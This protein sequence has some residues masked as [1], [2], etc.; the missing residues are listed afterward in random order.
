MKIPWLW[1]PA[2]GLLLVLASLCGCAVNPVTGRS[3]LMLLSEQ[4]ERQLGFQAR[5]SVDEEYGVYDDAALQSYVSG[6]ARPLAQASHRPALDWQFQVMDSPVVN[7]FAAPGGYV[8]VTR[9]LL[10]AVNDEAELAGVLAHEIG[11]VTARHSARNYSQSLLANIG[12]Q[13][14]TVLAGSYGNLLG[15]MLEAG[16]GLL[17]LK[18]SRDDERQA[19][20][21]GVEYASK[22][23]YDTNRMAD[24]FTTLQRQEVLEGE[25]GGGLP[26][27]FSTHPSPVDRE[28]AVRAQ[29]AQWRNQ[30][31]RQSY[32]TNREAFLARI[33][34]LVYGEDPRQGF[35]EGDWFYLPQSQVQFRIPSQ[36][37]FSRE[38]SQAQMT[39]PQKAGVILFAIQKGSV[40]QVAQSF[41]TSM[42][43]TVQQ[44][45][46]RFINGLQAR[47]LVS[48]VTDGKQKAR[49]ISHFFQKGGEVFM[50]HGL[51]DEAGFSRLAATLGQPAASFA[52]LT[53]REKLNRKPQR[54][55]VKQIGKAA[56]L[57]AALQAYAV[58]RNLWPRIAWMNEMQ[59]SDRLQPGQRI[60]IIE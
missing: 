13:L 18:Y 24:F 55:A 10:A 28:A 36:W 2:G 56:T 15:P 51:A 57:E 41:V 3:E 53:D 14:G 25:K 11:H 60:K 4:E 17:F 40:E 52:P 47:E 30:L 58:D 26:E 5:Q 48:T 12:V 21:L 54:I 19:D 22:G 16:T 45:A 31:P 46:E 1:K 23:G 34:G 44:S 49:V 38:G 32:R 8:F 29:T 59:L 9:G 6:V 50:F 27:W 20:S 42:N 7:A 43:A 39:H 33:D 37:G 35:R